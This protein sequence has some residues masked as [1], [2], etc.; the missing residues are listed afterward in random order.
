MSD[1]PKEWIT[2][3]EVVATI[4]M[5]RL[6]I[7]AGTTVKL[8]VAQAPSDPEYAIVQAGAIVVKIH[9]DELE[10]PEDYGDQN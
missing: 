3:S 2:R 9:W 5:V 7:P 4:G 8:L 10:R 1:L 6:P